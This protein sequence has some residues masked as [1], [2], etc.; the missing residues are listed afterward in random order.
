M[1]TPEHNE[2]D[3]K[4]LLETDSE[5]RPLVQ[6]TTA[7][8]KVALI[9][10]VP[11]SALEG[12][13]WNPLA[14]F[15]EFLLQRYALSPGMMWLVLQLG[16]LV[17]F[18]VFLR[19]ALAALLF[20]EPLIEVTYLPVAGLRGCIYMT[21]VLFILSSHILW[22]EMNAERQSR[23]LAAFVNEGHNADLFRDNPRA[24]KM[25]A[26]VLEARKEERRVKNRQSRRGKRSRHEARA[27]EY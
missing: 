10:A 25:R 18:W 27:S 19:I 12:F 11:R 17:A 3:G 14:R 24:K 15:G 26:A 16:G 21:A 6:E 1:D 13:Q 2:N 23:L 22:R 7:A 8:P 9:D 4:V 20:L 5:A